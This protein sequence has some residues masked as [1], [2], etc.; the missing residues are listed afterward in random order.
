[1]MSF[2]E[3]CHDWLPRAEPTRQEAVVEMLGEKDDVHGIINAWT[4]G[5]TG[6][7]LDLGF[8]RKRSNPITA[9]PRQRG[10]LDCSTSALFRGVLTLP[11]LYIQQ[12]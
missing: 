4:S 12:G 7:L 10:Q 5:P 6:G 1:M 11:P 2:Y 9:T 3:E 8:G